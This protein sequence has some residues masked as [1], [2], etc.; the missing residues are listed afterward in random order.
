MMMMFENVVAGV[1]CVC[2][3]GVRALGRAARVGG[4][5]N[6]PATTTSRRGTG[7]PC[8]SLSSLC[9]TTVNSSCAS[10]W[11][12]SDQRRLL[13]RGGLTSEVSRQGSRGAWPAWRGG[14]G[15]TLQLVTASK[16][17]RAAGRSSSSGIS[18]LAGTGPTNPGAHQLGT[19]STGDWWWPSDPWCS[20]SDNPV[21]Q[22]VWRERA[23]GAM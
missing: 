12:E 16:C 3:V 9:A 4:R 13:G 21:E 11:Q 2:T 19:K 10:S 8:T 15:G 6:Q 7:A 14:G 5:T 17:S 22:Q 18:G 23:S 20:Q 1:V